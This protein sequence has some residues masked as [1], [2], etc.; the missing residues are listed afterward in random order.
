MRLLGR[1]LRCGQLATLTQ[2]S[3]QK[4][5]KSLGSSVGMNHAFVY[6]VVV[7]RGFSPAR[8]F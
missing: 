6:S 5:L 7:V 2:R 1:T 3:N 8:A 4:N